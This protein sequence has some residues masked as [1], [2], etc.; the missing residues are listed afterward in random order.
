MV[1]MNA[2][3]IVQVARNAWSV[4]MRPKGHWHTPDGYDHVHLCG[5]YADAVAFVMA[6]LG[7]S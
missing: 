5:S 1:S 4:E 6:M 2:V 3:R 7:D